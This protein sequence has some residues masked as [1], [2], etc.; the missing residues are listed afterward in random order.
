LLFLLILTF[1]SCQ[2]TERPEKIN[3]TIIETSDVHGAV[4]PY[5]FL[6]DQASE[7]S[8]AQIHTYVKM[9]KDKANQVVLLLDN[10]DILQGDP[11]VY[12]YN[13][14]NTSGRH[15]MSEVMNYMKYDAGVVG[16]HDIEP[17]HAVYDKIEKE[18]EFPWLAANAIDVSSG[19][20]YFSPYTL[21]KKHG[22][23]IAVLGLTTPA[24]PQWLPP[25]IWEGMEFEDMIR[26]ARYWQD[27]IRKKE[28]PDLLIGLFHSGYDY[29]YNNQNADTPYNE[30]A[31]KLVA[32]QVPGFDLVFVGHDHHGWNVTVTNDAGNPVN[33]LGTTSRAQDIAVARIEMKLD[34]KTDQYQK[35]IT[36]EIVPM[37]NIR[38]DTQFMARFKPHFDEIKS[39]VSK[40][41]G[42]MAGTITTRDAFFGDAPFTDLIHRAQM[43]LTGA[44][45]SFTAPLSF[46]KSIEKGTLHVRDLFKIYR[47]EN[48]IYTMELT[49]REIKDY[50]EYSCGLWF[51]EMKDADDNM[52][53]FRKDKD[54]DLIRSGDRARLH[55]AF[56]NFDNAEGINYHVDLSKPVGQR[57][58]IVSMADGAPFDFDKTFAV[59]VNSYR[60]NGGG[61]HLVAG[62]KIPA[63]EL[64]DRVIAST[65]KDFRFY[66]MNW[67][68]E[69]DSVKPS[70]N[71]NWEI[72]PEEWIRKSL[73][74]DRRL[75][76]VPDS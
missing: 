13:F 63:R 39:Y 69:Q 31:S 3:F 8:L 7:N 48:L 49:G 6:E 18:F 11:G 42:Y 4:F 57:I 44:E 34:N 16:N 28:Q 74:R 70:V 37:K 64:A 41:L 2:R 55:H 68:A 29:T 73:P 40:P 25:G 15:L 24:I 45:I 32:E 23:K 60:G 52:L 33:I 9:E 20:P 51:D 66:L 19:E 14:E 65:G 27:V 35:T 43:D 36:G 5:D 59:A 58:H 38:P 1:A 26:S 12:Y 61:G 71:N 56:Y 53:R 75:L 30:N 76:F 72:L 54:G 47:Y 62:A 50:L 46:D 17:G 21:L 67:I 22:I 10:G